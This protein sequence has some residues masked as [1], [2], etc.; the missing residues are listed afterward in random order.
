MSS[1]QPTTAARP[2]LAFVLL[3][4]G[5]LLAALNLPA[6][7][8]IEQSLRRVLNIK[9]VI[10]SPLQLGFSFSLYALA[11]LFAI[12][13]WSWVVDRLGYRRASIVALLL[14]SVG[15]LGVALT[16]TPLFKADT[17]P[18]WLVGW[19]VV[20]GLG[21]GAL[22]PLAIA[23]I[24]SLVAA[25]RDRLIHE[26]RIR[27]VT[28]AAYTALIVAALLGTSYAS[29]VLNA[30]I[31]WY[32]LFLPNLIFGLSAA[33]LFNQVAPAEDNQEVEP[34]WWAWVAVWVCL[35]TLILTALTIT[36]QLELGSH[37]ATEPDLLFRLP[38]LPRHLVQH[39]A[40]CHRGVERFDL[41]EHGEAEQ[42]VALLGGE[43]LQAAP[44]AAYHQQQRAT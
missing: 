19:R 13:N 16:G 27:K 2:V 6:T 21:G 8:A 43:P 15:S 10:A 30:L 36:H 17:G 32:W 42:V 14:F 4:Q 18:N 41:A 1:P 33:M 5:S 35:L 24:P 9:V 23:L 20:Q 40:A 34:N 12:A 31:D 26:G 29:F 28:A 22:V 7:L 11:L 38:P 25:P 3:L 44:L 37:I 39:D